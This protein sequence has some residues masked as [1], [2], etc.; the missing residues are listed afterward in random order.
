VDLAPIIKEALKLMRASLPTTIEIRPDISAQCGVVLA[1]P[2]QIHQVLMNLCTNAYHAM[3][4]TGGVL[5]VALKPCTVD[6][7]LARS[8]PQLI[9]GEYV[10]LSVSDTGKGME[11]KTVER[12]FEPFFTTKQV[13]EGTGLGLSVVH[14]IVSRYDGAITVRSE[15]GTGSTFNVYLPR[16]RAGEPRATSESIPA[17]GGNERILIVDDEPAVA[18]TLKR[19]LE[20]FG[21]EVTV[22]NSSTEALELYRSDPSHYDLVISDQT[23]PHM[24]G[25]QLARELIA[26][27][28]DV[29][30]ILMTGYS[31]AVDEERCK[32]LGINR[33]LMKPIPAAELARAVREV[34]DSVAVS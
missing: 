12:I 30:I 22:R 33:F 15:A 27:R 8:H 28:T 3:R 25:D 2:S 9:P 32:R 5:T 24:T 7:V 26:A 19:L 31:Q 11:Q 16:V 17:V 4:D 10:Q 29:A 6:E 21:Y 23:M 13:G 14:G 20:R 18:A 1:D 34:L